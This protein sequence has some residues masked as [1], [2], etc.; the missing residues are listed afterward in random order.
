MKRIA[1]LISGIAI[2]LVVLSGCS[3]SSATVATD[4]DVTT[5]RMAHGISES[6]EGGKA[7]AQLSDSVDEKS[8]GTMNLE[9]YGSGVLG[10]E[11]DTVE[12][13]Q[14]GVLDM[15]KVGASSLDAFEP[16]YGV[17]SLP[18]MFDSEEDLYAAMTSTD[19]IKQLND[20][21]RDT[22][23]IMIGWYPSGFRNFYTA[24]DTPITS[25]D[26]LKGM[27][28]RVMESATSK[29]LVETLGGS[30]VPM[31]S[32]ETYTA[33]QQ[34]VIDGAEN[35]ELALT[36]NRHMDVAKS[37]SY[38]QH[39]MVPDIYIISTKTL[40]RLTDDQLAILE[41]ALWENNQMYRELNQSLI[42]DAI[43][44]SKEAG[45]EFVDVDKAPFEEKVKPMYD[46]FTSQGP[47]YQEIFNTVKGAAGTEADY[48]T[49]EIK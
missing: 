49:P 6:S 3:S 2:L 32:S 36:S 7:I 37:Y 14:A 1:S 22:G 39:Q 41:D 24:K 33:M 42:Q 35:N 5:I 31:A 19:V 44:E 25:P 40:D 34:G 4:D 8:N 9:I 12:M 45:V 28:I 10:S 11:R 29:K 27:K 38:T 43:T 23:F 46:D 21:T 47:E 18:Y 17:F 16:L 48:D 15:A 30:P 13:V 26:D 20:A